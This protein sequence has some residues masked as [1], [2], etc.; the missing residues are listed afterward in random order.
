MIN[1]RI[2]RIKALQVLYSHFKKEGQSLQNAE[3]ELFH[4]IQ[5]SYDL[6]HHLFW[7]IVEIKKFAEERIELNRNKKIP[8]Q[9]DL[10]P[11][12][13][14]IDNQ[15][16]DQIFNNEDLLKYLNQNK[17]NWMNNPEVIKRVFTDFERSELY[18][19][20]INSEDN[21]YSESKQFISKVFT[22]CLM[23][24]EVVYEALEEQSIYWN[25]EIEYVLSM[26]GKTI[27]K[28]EEKKSNNNEIVTQFND[29]DDKN[30][31]KTL[32]RKTIMNHEE[33]RLLIEENTKNWEVDRI[34]YMDTIILEMAITELVEFPH[35]PIK[36]SFNEYLELSKIYSTAKS[37]TFI[38]GIL[39]KMAKKLIKE[40][41]IKK[42]GRG[43]IDN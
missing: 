11:I 8:S 18:L 41:T 29:E 4:S 39:D 40:G 6:Y 15:V 13:K 27:K 20:Y 7:L 30:F 23:N 25:D 28:F 36:V 33:N 37:S 1:R 14:F 2:L 12:T 17:L 32:I 43:L 21:S 26:I 34:A 10:N 42:V 19:T 35:I 31:I 3:K 16:I 9:E 22:D 5:R 24:I 38:N